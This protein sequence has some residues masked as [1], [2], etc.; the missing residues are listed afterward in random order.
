MMILA[1]KLNKGKNKELLQEMKAKCF[2]DILVR[3]G[4][5]PAELKV[6]QSIIYISDIPIELLAQSYYEYIDIGLNPATTDKL[7]R[8]MLTNED[9]ARFFGD[10]KGIDFE[11]A[12]YTFHV[13]R[14]SII[15]KVTAIN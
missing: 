4:V 9:Y 3:Y 6:L 2:P 14:K 1:T 5:P 13:R 10:Y 8:S 7:R 12:I 11:N 15:E